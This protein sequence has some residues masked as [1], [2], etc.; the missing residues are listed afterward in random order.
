MIASGASWSKAFAA[1]GASQMSI[2]D[3][4][5]VRAMFFPW[6]CQLVEALDPAEGSSALDVGT[7]PG[8]VARVLALR[9]GSSGRI[10]A[11]D[12]S[13]AMLELARNK[14]PLSKGAP[15]EYVE[16][17]AA[18]LA[19][20]SSEFDLVTC[21]QVLQF[22]PD[23][24]AALKEMRRALRPGGRIGLTTW[25]A[26]T[27]NPMFLGLQTAVR[28]VL[29]DGPAQQFEGPW[30]LSG[31]RVA[32]LM[33]TTGFNDIVLHRRSLPL[34]LPGAADAAR[35]VFAFSSL[36]ATLSALDESQREALRAAVRSELE[37]LRNG[38]VIES[39]TTASLVC[40]R[41]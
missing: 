1:G 26:I 22:A 36:A 2:Y 38:D 29:G 37:P 11:T 24:H 41:R 21:Q 7:G 3:E 15:I 10:I 27:E 28:K 33:E 12:I 31:E 19:V 39:V 6:A 23:P 34:T 16:S 32:E 5:L 8:T 14:L 25:T 35:Q 17:P 4:L 13:P 40:A 30:S 9:L 18:P 20:S